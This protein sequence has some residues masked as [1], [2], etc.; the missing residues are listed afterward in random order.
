MT[1]NNL[2]KAAIGAF[3]MLAAV[4]TIYTFATSSGKEAK[5]SIY[6]ESYPFNVPPHYSKKVKNTRKYESYMD[7]YNDIERTIP[8]K[9][10][11]KDQLKV[12]KHISDVITNIWS[13]VYKNGLN[14]FKGYTY[15]RIYSLGSKEATNPV[16]DLPQEAITF[17]RY[18]DNST[19]EFIGNQRIKLK[20]LYPDDVVYVWSWYQS[21]LSNDEIKQIRLKHSSGVSK[22]YYPAQIW[23]ENEKWYAENY[24]LIKATIFILG[25]FTL[26]FFIVFIVDASSSKKPDSDT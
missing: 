23:G 18:S 20:N 1:F 11:H 4:I 24:K 6:T 26:M 10:S 12:S 16:L 14:S 2:W 3:G 22:P 17:I 8:K 13:G 7:V 19:E 5:L 15:S 21:R 9:L 25:F